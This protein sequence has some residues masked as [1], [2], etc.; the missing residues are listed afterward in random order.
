MIRSSLSLRLP[1][2]LIEEIICDPS[3]IA[4]PSSFRY[5]DLASGISITA[6]LVRLYESG[7]GGLGFITWTQDTLPQGR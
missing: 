2:V 4:G 5:F 7:H 1:S 3:A 6:R